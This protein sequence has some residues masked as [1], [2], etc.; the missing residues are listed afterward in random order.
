PHAN[1]LPSLLRRSLENLPD[2]E[3]FPDL[4]SLIVGT[5]RLYRHDVELFRA[6]LGPHCRLSN[7][8]AA[9]EASTIAGGPVD[10]GDLPDG[11]LPIGPVLPGVEVTIHDPDATGIGEIV[12]RSDHLA[13]SE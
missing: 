9:A 6:K 13:R 3:N 4:R 12:V 8:Y 1:T 2:G 11:V 10:D 7:V 5:E